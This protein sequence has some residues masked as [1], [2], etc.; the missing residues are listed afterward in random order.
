M[1][2]RMKKGMIAAALATVGCLYF[3]TAAYAAGSVTV[4]ADKETAVVGENIR[5]TVEATDP[6][7]GAEAPEISVEYDPNRLAYLNC[8]ATCDG[9]AGGLLKLTDT[10]ANIDFSV[11]SG[12][13][14]TVN[15]SAILGGDGADVQSGSVSVSVEGEDTAAGMGAEAMPV[16]TG[17]EAGTIMSS[18]GT[19]VVSTVFPDE[20]MPPSFTKITT[21]YQGQQTEAAQFNDVVLLYMTNTD[22]S[23]GGFY[24]YDETTGEISDF[25]SINGI[26]GK[27]IIMLP[28]GAVPVP[29]G[30]T[31]AKLKWGE[32][33]ELEAYMVTDDAL[34]SADESEAD[35]AISGMG[36]S[37]SEFFLVYAENA[38]GNKFW[39]MYDTV[40]GTFQRY[41][42]IATSKSEKSGLASLMSSASDGEDDGNGSTVKLIIIGVLAL[43]IVI[44]AIIMLNMFLKLRD[45]QSYD[46][47][48]ED[49]IEEEDEEDEE[50]KEDDE[51]EAS[52]RPV[53]KSIARTKESERTYRKQI[54]AVEKQFEDEFEGDDDLEILEDEEMMEEEFVEPKKRSSKKSAVKELTKEE[55]RELKEQQKAEKARRKHMGDFEAAG[56]I[57]WSEME[58]QMKNTDDERR[59][60]GNNPEMLP[61]QYREQASENKE[62]QQRQQAPQPQSTQAAQMQRHHETR[63]QPQR[64]N[65]MSPKPQRLQSP[66]AS[67]QVQIPG[68]GMGRAAGMPRQQSHPQMS[69][70]LQQQMPQQMPQMPQ[71]MLQMPQQM[72][73]QM[74]SQPRDYDFDDDFEFEF[75]NLDE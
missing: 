14:A 6:S 45:Y 51:Q 36:V 73:Q 26:E 17:V 24:R 44:M 3:A 58:N 10:K 30:F 7:D 16:A 46:Y 52:E 50:D 9:G 28:A 5:I 54:R 72:Y 53:E 39:Y 69:S 66:Q 65:E 75:L 2:Q 22:G 71:Q 23:N 63:P 56:S 43:I 27:F 67:R 47:I 25:V 34:T 19:K 20:F 57:D 13:M 70:H 32:E 31:K 12:G 1:I 29:E 55:K 49:D 74:P 60:R 62:Q 8:D 18:D 61:K 11:L 41:L 64:T 42:P 33:K 68:Q 48:D 59:P 4:T 38:D 15:V 35:S 37:S 40:E 21:T